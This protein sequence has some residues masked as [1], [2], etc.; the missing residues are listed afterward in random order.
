[1]AG[2]GG[3]T[4]VAKGFSRRLLLRLEQSIN[5]EQLFKLKP[6][7]ELESD[8]R[9]T[10]E[11]QAVI[12]AEISLSESRRNFNTKNA[13]YY[14]SIKGP[15]ESRLRIHKKIIVDRK[16][17]IDRTNK[18][19]FITTASEIRDNCIYASAIGIKDPIWL[20]KVCENLCRLIQSK[21]FSINSF[22]FRRSI[23]SLESK[24]IAG[25]RKAGS[26]QPI[27]SIFL[28]W[29]NETEGTA[30]ISPDDNFKALVE[31]CRRQDKILD[32]YFRKLEFKSYLDFR[33]RKKAS[34][35]E[36]LSQ[37]L[38]LAGPEFIS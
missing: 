18:I 3:N 36:R 8:I 15:V 10:P 29:I 38:K 24:I 19:L 25:S 2:R 28:D 11:Y 14:N 31:A 13:A 35:H 26:R 27:D 1:V 20:G 30:G 4:P 12:K 9:N 37:L 21:R 17:K 32:K 16:T 7:P 34:V 6:I 33:S 5:D 23:K 22:H